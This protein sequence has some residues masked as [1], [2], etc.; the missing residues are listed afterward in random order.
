LVPRQRAII[1]GRVRSVRVQPWSGTASL[2]CTIAD[3]TGSMNVVWYG[4]RA[5][6]GIRVGT[7]LSI[8]GTVGRHRGMDAVLNPAYTIISTPAAPE[9]PHGTTH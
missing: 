1:A 9:T 4:R 7:V 5:L 2:E 3:E 8:V 6:G